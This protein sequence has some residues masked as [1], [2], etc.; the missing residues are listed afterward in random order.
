[1]FRDAYEPCNDKQIIPKQ[2]FV[3]VTL[4]LLWCL[5]QMSLTATIAHSITLK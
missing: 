3:I 1:M 4:L 5:L 2:L